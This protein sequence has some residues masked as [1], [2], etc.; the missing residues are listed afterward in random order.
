[1]MGASRR[2]RDG[3]IA[4]LFAAA[5]AAFAAA[6]CLAAISPQAA[7]A[8]E[9]LARLESGRYDQAR[10]LL[11]PA[12]QHAVSVQILAAN[13]PRSNGMMTRRIAYEGP[14]SMVAA[15]AKRPGRFYVLCY[16]DLPRGRSGTVRHVGV[17]LVQVLAGWRVSDYRYQS[18]PH[19]ACSGHV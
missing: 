8:S 18:V 7:A 9:F 6:P 12:T 5:V 17:I 15:Q 11:D 16:L 13:A 14:I 1:M 3:A 19:P 4:A 10:L 2:P